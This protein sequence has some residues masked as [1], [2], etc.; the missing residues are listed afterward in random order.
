MYSE[1][2]LKKSQKKIRYFENILKHCESA[3]V[4]VWQ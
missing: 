2:A 3:S 4:C 1:M